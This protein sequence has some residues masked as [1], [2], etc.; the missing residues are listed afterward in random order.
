VIAPKER[1][2]YRTLFHLMLV[3]ALQNVVAYSV[4]VA[5]NIM[6]GNYSQAALSGAATVNQ[7]QFL[8]QSVA[9]SIG[10]AIVM[11]NAQYYGKG[12]LSPMRSVAGT[13]LRVGLI[14]GVFVFLLTSLFPSELLGLFTSD[15]EII[16]AGTEYLQLMR[17]TYLLYILSTILLA[18]LRGVGTVNIAFALSG[19]SLILNVCINYTLIFGHFGF[20]EL[21]IQ[22]AAIGTLT[23]RTIELLVVIFYILR[24]DKKLRL[25]A[26]NP[27]R[28][29]SALSRDF[30]RVALPV[31]ATSFIWCL[32]TP[33]QTGILGHLSSDA[34]A[35]NSVSSTMF[36]YT[37]VVTQGACSAAA[38]MVGRLVGTGM[39]TKPQLRPY[40]RRLQLIFLGLGIVLG[41][42]L[43]L[44]RGPILSLY[45]LSTEA[46]ALADSLMK[47]MVLIFLGMSYQMPTLFGIVRGGGDTR[48]NMIN[49]L[50]FT[51][52][53]V[54]PLS[55]AAAFWWKLPVF[56]VV[57]F[58]NCDQLLKCV[59]AFLYANS[60]R[61]VHV[62]TRDT[63]KEEETQ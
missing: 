56:W 52:G 16:A 27:F 33:I 32:A 44:I 37:K 46:M 58:L 9:T 34:I 20:P 14:V 50:V 15:P 23:A 19:M 22:G 49:N 61:W 26:E 41:G 29:D 35:A 40:V 60:Y 21:G 4:N 53:V 5:D 17:F 57:F 28:R 30:H 12:Q 54:M 45:A 24:V 42:V 13:G 2:F 3:V 39:T 36:Q 1:E 55:F 11:I 6:L 8:V 43:Y 59:P 10:D 62:L 31:V 18:A 48:F 38:V 25:F 7:I 51:W 47:L 63:E